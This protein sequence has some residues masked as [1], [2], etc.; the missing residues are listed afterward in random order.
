M[1]KILKTIAIISLLLLTSCGRVTEPQ[2]RQALHNNLLERYGEE[3]EI[4]Y[5]GRRLDGKET[6]Y[7]AEIYP[8]KYK[9]TPKEYDE[10][11]H[12]S[13]SVDIEKSIF[14]EKISYIYKKKI[15]IIK[16]FFDGENFTKEMKA[17]ICF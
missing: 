6:W 15:F 12:S 2:A 3:F 7:E 1:K 10:Y 8:A 16:Y 4:G 9:G 13:G 17:I 14:G 11:Y 5:M